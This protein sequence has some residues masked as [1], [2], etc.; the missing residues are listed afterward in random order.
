MG[1]LRHARKRIFYCKMGAVLRRGR[2]ENHG[3]FRVAL[4]W[5]GAKLLELTHFRARGGRFAENDAGAVLGLLN[6]QR[7][8]IGMHTPT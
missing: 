5:G 6:C 1:I 8:R 3:E 7:S 2:H 4:R